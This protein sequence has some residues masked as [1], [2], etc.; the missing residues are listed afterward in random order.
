MNTDVIAWA[1]GR[2]EGKRVSKETLNNRA[3][4]ELASGLDVYRDTALLPRLRA[5]GFD[6]R[7]GLIPANGGPTATNIQARLRIP[8]PDTSPDFS[9]NPTNHTGSV[10][11]RAPG[12]APNARSAYASYLGLSLDPVNSFTAEGWIRL[13]DEPADIN[14]I[15]YVAGNRRTANGWMLTL[16]RDASN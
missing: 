5:L 4:I 14:S 13:Y 15:F 11:F 12:E 6:A 2:P 16:R 8:N 9:G 3:L 1:A 10:F 7:F